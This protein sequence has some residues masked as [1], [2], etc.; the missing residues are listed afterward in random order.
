M[1]MM[2]NLS[3][4]KKEMTKWEWNNFFEILIP[5]SGEEWLFLIAFA[6]ITLCTIGVIRDR[7]SYASVVMVTFIVLNIFLASMYIF[8]GTQDYNESLVED[9]KN[10]LQEVAFESIS[11]QYDL[12]QNM[13]NNIEHKFDEEDNK[14]ALKRL[15]FDY[16]DLASSTTYELNFVFDGNGTAKIMKTDSVTDEVIK[17]FE[18]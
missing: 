14:V 1:I 3:F 10:N 12:D 9:G 15:I 13:I 8:E 11:G 16:D 2:N 17:Q 6:I 5:S 7:A 4:D 18:K